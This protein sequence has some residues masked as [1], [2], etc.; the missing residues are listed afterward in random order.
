MAQWVKALTA[1]PDGLSLTYT[2]KAENRLHELTSD[3]HM[4]ALVHHTDHTHAHAHAHTHTHT[5]TLQK[6]K[7]SRI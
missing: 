3:L 2:M 6:E 7:D 5:H 4:C 1:K